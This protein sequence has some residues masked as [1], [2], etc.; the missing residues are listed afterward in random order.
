M[1]TQKVAAEYRMA[2]WAQ[3]I[4]ERAGSGQSIKDFCQNSGISRNAYFYWQRKLRE[5][6]CTELVKKEEPKSIAPDGW[7]QLASESMR[8]R[9]EPLAIEING[10]RITVTSDTDHGLLAKVCRTLRS[11]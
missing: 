7:V 11:L 9:T 8:Q 3:V 6:A 2:Q 10:C 1:N 5:S 4:Q